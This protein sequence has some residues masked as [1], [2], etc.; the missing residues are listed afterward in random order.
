MRGRGLVI[1]VAV[2]LVGL[3]AGVTWRHA[4]G[5]PAL[6]RRVDAEG[7]GGPR[8]TGRRHGGLC[9]GL[10]APGLPLPRGPRPAPRLPHRV[11]VLDGQPLHGGRARL[12]LPVHP[13]PQRA[14]PRGQG[15]HVR[16]GHAAGV[17]GAPR[18]L[19]HRRR[20]LPRLRALQ[21]RHA[22]TRGRAGRALQVWLEDWSAEAT[23][24]RGHAPHRTGR[25]CV[26]V[27]GAGARQAPGAPGRPGPEPEGARAGQRLLLLLAHADALARTGDGGRAARTR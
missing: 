4:R 22:G 21:P 7:G 14:R 27:P 1:G 5:R 23:G 24:E 17:H 19:G 15:A 20:A 25:G 8:R 2:V 3:A 13:L 12:R 11:V 9:A 16:V 10:R 18:A 6:G 26:A